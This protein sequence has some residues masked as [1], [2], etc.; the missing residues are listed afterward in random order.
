MAGI[1]RET[2]KLLDGFAHVRQSLHVIFTTGI[3]TRIMR[4]L[5][6]SE[7]PGLL[8]KNI[9]PSTFLRFATAVHVALQLWEPRFR[10]VQVTFPRD[11]A[12][13][14]NVGANTP[15]TVRRGRI[16]IALY[17]EYRP[18]GHLGDPTPEGGAQTIIL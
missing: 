11:G 5:F 10:L 3:G 15:E 8:G 12:L 6:G 13:E 4:R 7:I 14:P 18:R 1:D 17:G 2:G 9:V 16:G